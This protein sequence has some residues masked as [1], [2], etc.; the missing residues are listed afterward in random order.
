MKWGKVTF[1]HIWET[2]AVHWAPLLIQVILSNIDREW[3]DSVYI[4]YKS[5]KKLVKRIA[6]EDDEKIRNQLMAQF[7]K[8]INQVL[9]F[10][11]HTISS[12]CFPKI[13]NVER[14]LTFSTKHRSAMHFV[15]LFRTWA[16]L[17]P[18]SS[19]LNLDCSPIWNLSRKKHC[20][21]WSPNYIGLKLI[22]SS[23]PKDSG[24]S[25]KNWIRSSMRIHQN[26]L[27]MH[28]CSRRQHSMSRSNYANCTERYWLCIRH[29][30]FLYLALCKC[31]SILNCCFPARWFQ[32]QSNHSSIRTDSDYFVG[33]ILSPICL[34]S[35][36]CG[37]PRLLGCDGCVCIVLADGWKEFESA[38]N[39][40]GRVVHV[41]LVA[42]SYSLLTVCTVQH[43]TLSFRNGY[44]HYF[45]YYWLSISHSDT[46]FIGASDCGGHRGI[47][48]WSIYRAHTVFS[49]HFAPCS[50]SSTL[51]GVACSMREWRSL[52]TGIV[53]CGCDYV[54]ITMAVHHY[55]T[56][57]FSGIPLNRCIIT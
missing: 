25:S 31:L 21:L 23:M 37:L 27:S 49:Q 43:S 33:P 29:W 51:C 17:M 1:N 15:L 28:P 30:P 40:K 35:F 24:K 26:A 56:P 11:L 4:H 53:V 50:R 5:L 22:L 48:K 52:S 54:S 9:Y 36:C 55:L 16:L 7:E 38:D 46:T 41:Y 12:F 6:E 32:L 3:G 20:R 8:K 42:V 34:S 13:H 14:T 44:N 19:W 47:Q 2:L 45:T 57:S 10:H 18:I 39:H